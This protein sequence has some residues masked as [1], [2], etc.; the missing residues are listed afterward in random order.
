MS[1]A[2][3][4]TE[5][6]Q[7]LERTKAVPRDHLL[8]HIAL[9]GPVV[10]G[11]LVSVNIGDITDDGV[12]IREAITVKGEDVR[13]AGRLEKLCYLSRPARQIAA[14]VVAERRKRCLHSS[15][16]RALGSYA[17]ADGVERC[18]ACRRPVDWRRWPLF[19]STRGRRPSAS[20]ARKRFAGWRHE[21]G[22]P[23]DL[24]FEALRA[25]YDVRASAAVRQGLSN[26]E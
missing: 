1:R 3:T 20:Q 23:D 7:L 25:T 15:A 11:E 10:A 13:R 6:Q 21:L 19:E 22:W 12:Q 16:G 5:R 4:G 17:E 9:A 8:F 26:E 24:T 2:L 18:H 14:A